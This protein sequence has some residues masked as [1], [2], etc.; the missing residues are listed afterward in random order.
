[1]APYK[2]QTADTINIQ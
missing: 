1:M 2:Y